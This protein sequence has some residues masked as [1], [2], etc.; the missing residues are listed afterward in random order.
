MLRPLRREILERLREPASATEV[1]KALGLPR[2]RVNY[3]VRA[4]HAAGFLLRAGRRRRRGLFEQRYRASA[5]A[6]VLSPRVLGPLAPRGFETA[7][8]TSAVR[9]LAMLTWAQAEVASA[10]RGARAAAELLPTLA[11]A[12]TLRFETEE[13]RAAFVRALEAAVRRVLVRHAAPIRGR[14]DGPVRG[15]PCRLV[16]GLHPLPRGRAEG[17]P[18]DGE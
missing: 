16:L 9:L 2:Q 17:G 11:L 1:A 13:R 4:L 8:T 3:H 7:D 18:H 15:S 6:Y 10:L 14:A 12:A 5:R